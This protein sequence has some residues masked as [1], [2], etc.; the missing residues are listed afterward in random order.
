MAIASYPDDI[1]GVVVEIRDKTASCFLSKS[2][3]F[4]RDIVIAPPSWYSRTKTAAFPKGVISCHQR[5]D[6]LSVQVGDLV[7]CTNCDEMMGDHHE[8]GRWWENGSRGKVIK[9]EQGSES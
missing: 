5:P 2:E 1:V 3:L 6:E 4:L 8:G 9:I 7:R